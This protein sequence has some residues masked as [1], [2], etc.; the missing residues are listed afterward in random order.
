MWPTSAQLA[1]A[2]VDDR[3]R[4]AALCGA[5]LH[6]DFPDSDLSRM[7]PAY[8][9]GLEAADADAAVR[10]GWGLWLVIFKRDRLVV[11][12]VGFKGPPS[13][14]GEIAVGYGI[15]RAHRRRG[16]AAEATAALVRWAFVDARVSRIIAECAA[17][18]AASFGVLR[19]VGFAQLPDVSA[20]Q[21]IRWELQRADWRQANG[22]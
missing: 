8:A 3:R 18:N 21:S 6:R 19:R 16:L 22:Y 9:A 11:G 14:R 7:L 15:V 20:A 13:P 5:V 12:G 1:R 17:D 10:A 4:A 2:L